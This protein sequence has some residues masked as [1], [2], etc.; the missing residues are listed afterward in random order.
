MREMTERCHDWTLAQLEVVSVFGP[1]FDIDERLSIKVLRTIEWSIKLVNRRWKEIYRSDI[2]VTRYLSEVFS[3]LES[4]DLTNEPL[5][6]SLLIMDGVTIQNFEVYFDYHVFFFSSVAH[7]KCLTCGTGSQFLC[8]DLKLNSSFLA[9]RPRL[10]YKILPII[11][12]DFTWCRKWWDVRLLVP[13]VD[14]YG[15]LLVFHLFRHCI[16]TGLAQKLMLGL[17][18]RS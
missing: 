16:L 5:H 10:F 4:I 9:I 1:L 3:H 15:F 18:D 2:E 6:G 7:F 8:L 13:S 11:Q 17:L 12:V 14:D